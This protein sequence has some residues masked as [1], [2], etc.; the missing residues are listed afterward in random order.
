MSQ[1]LPAT[2]YAILGLLTF[3]DELTGY[4]IKQR[5]DITLRFYWVS[6]AMSQIYTELRRLTDRGLVAAAARTDGG[7]EVTSYAI[8]ETGQ[9]ALRAWMDGTPAGFPVLKHTVLLRLLVGHA[10]EPEQTARM[11]E[12]YVAELAQATADLAEV[13]ESLRG[14]D[15]PGE[16]LRFPSLVA[17]WGLDYFAA[18]TRH[19]HRALDSLQDDRSA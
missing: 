13:R 11:L 3:G 2:G 10:T 6:P 7:R 9:A 15:R 14:A 5:A 4:E 17:D 19:A 8:T 18:E 1:D 16:P 12:E